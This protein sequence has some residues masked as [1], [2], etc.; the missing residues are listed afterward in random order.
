LFLFKK[1]IFITIFKAEPEAKPEFPFE[2]KKYLREKHNSDP[3]FK[4]NDR[5]T[6]LHPL[7]QIKPGFITTYDDTFKV[8]P[9]DIVLRDF[10]GTREQ[11]LKNEA[12]FGGD[13]LYTS[14]TGIT[15]E[16]FVPICSNLENGID[17]L[18]TSHSKFK[19]KLKEKI[20]SLP[21]DR[22]KSSIP[23]VPGQDEKDPEKSQ[24]F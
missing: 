3:H 17:P 11:E 18:L 5:N 24:A 6:T 9:H 20:C 22:L 14:L 10:F 23:W 7:H 15:S 2:K 8:F 13:H 1:I 19:K 4:L 21:P 16:S 12:E